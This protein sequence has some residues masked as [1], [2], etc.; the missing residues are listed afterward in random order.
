MT[1][2]CTLVGGPESRLKGQQ[3][4]L[5]IDAPDGAAGADIC[6]QLAQKFGTGTV[7]V[8]GEDLRSVRFG[9]P[10]LVPGAVLI[11]G[12][13]VP[14]RRKQRRRPSGQPPAPLALAV[15]SGPGAGTVVP[16]RRGTYTIGRSNARIVIPDAELSRQHARLVV[17]ETNIIIVDLGSANGTYVDGER[18]RNAAVSTG[19]IIRCGNSTMSM[20][21]TDAPEKALS[22]A[23]ASVQEPILVRGRPES[24]SRTVLVATAGL[25]LI[26]GIGLAVLTGMWMFLA[27]AAA[28]A[29][30]LMVPLISGRRQRR[31]TLAAVNA[32]VDRDRHRRRASG[33]SLATLVLAGDRKQNLPAI[34]YDET[35]AW[36][37]LGQA[38]QPANVMVEPAGTDWKI[39][40]AGTVPVVLDLS[41][42][43]SAFQGTP[44]L[45]DGMIR[46]IIMQ[47]V[48][49]P[50]CRTLRLIIHGQ[51]G[52]LPLSARYLPGVTVTA[53]ADTCRSMMAEGPKTSCRK[54]VLLITGTTE[55]GT[56]NTLADE[57]L[58]RG[59]HVLEF[60]P[61]GARKR[62]VDVEL[63]E[64][65][66][67]LRRPAGDLVF[68]PDLA[69]EEVFNK[70]CRHLATSPRRQD[71]E[72]RSIPSTCLLDDVL[73]Q[74]AAQTAARWALSMKG[75][76]LA[77]PLGLG[78]SGARVLDLQEDGPHLLVAGTTGSGKSE[79]LRSL[80]LALALSHPPDRV[81][82]LFVDFKGGSGLG[83]L[84]GLV[85]CVGLL[86]DLS[87]Y[88]LERTLTSLRAEIRFR[89]EVLA[90]A[91]VPD[92]TA[93][94]SMP[95]C[96]GLVIPHLVIIIDEFRMLVDDA[97]EVLR[98]LMRI[99]SVGR[100]LGIHLVMATQRPQG[101]LT[102][103]I[104]ANVTSSIALR[105]QSDMESVDIIGSKEAAAISIDAPGRAFLARG[106]ERAQEFQ[107]ATTGLAP[108]GSSLHPAVNV[109]LAT[110][111]LASCVPAGVD[112]ESRTPADATASLVTLVGDLWAAMKGE[113]PRAPVAPPL[114]QDLQ[115]P[116]RDGP[117]TDAPA[118]QDGTFS[119][120][121]GLMDLPDS[122]KVQ[123]L[124]WKPVQDSHL[125]L[126]GAPASGAA[127]ALDL[128]VR[129][130]LVHRTEA[131]CYF[132]DGA[133]TLQYL[134]SHRR[135]G[136]HAGL[137][138]LRRG[139]RVLERLDRELTRRLSQPDDHTVPLLV[140]ISGWGSW[141]SAFRSGP[142]AWA[143]DLVQNLVRDGARAR[144]TVM[145]SGD[146]EL[147]SSRFCGALPNR[148]YFPAG[149][150]HDSRVAWP[151][152]PSTAAV[153]GRAVA[154]G[155]LSDGNAAV[156]QLYHIASNSS[157]C[158]D[159]V[160]GRTD[161]PAPRPFRVE[162][163]PARVAAAEIR[164]MAA[165]PPAS[166]KP[167][168]IP[169]G[170]PP[171][172]MLIG[173][174]GDELSPVSFR[175]PPGGV[176]A[177]LGGPGSGKTNVLRALQELNPAHR[178]LCPGAGIKD[179][180]WNGLLSQALAGQLPKETVVLADD[181][182]LMSPAA[183]H[184]LSELQAMGQPLVLTAGYSP[185]LLQRVPLVMSSRAAGTG[186]L[187][188][189]RSILDG[190]LFGVRFEVEPGPTPGRGVL[191]SG[192]RSCLIQV[193]WAPGT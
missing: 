156:C 127:E 47:L 166:G 57:A 26:I 129:H 72:E 5:S 112:M 126:I 89:E 134:A 7:T 90:S 116:R 59:W 48:A 70:F 40:S 30:A 65:G 1:L 49:Y 141:V 164:S 8:D 113:S 118:A 94:R 185:L 76:G 104:R 74:S 42:S 181:A 176:V 178:W 151:R 10:P 21:F 152:M 161:S 192:G 16:L 56:S 122:Q 193:G 165:S 149:S 6:Y 31:E 81:T 73:P 14:V 121:L 83:P 108:K 66:S 153:K 95:G 107:A 139:V 84:K 140:V 19:S 91:G 187:L 77:A 184:A 35:A 18:I 114:P 162:A 101:A 46:A 135:V 136:A 97:P 23:G 167:S 120:T 13:G 69:P 55:E 150:N 180:F 100:S 188:S 115:E 61:A 2:H 123:P 11:D 88:E 137:H 54:G 34:P 64:R 38:V 25:P 133:G 173:V 33:P 102:A 44:N 168:N 20:V 17:T 15:H 27:F 144:L 179:D 60:L 9:L 138:E 132:L 190:D 71:N 148:L 67:T 177:V 109:Q 128:A 119:I 82:F 85:H 51:A 52:R 131:H 191:I 12:G 125:A 63:L 155:P 186:V 147:V 130:A 28:S 163:L 79:L 174:G 105:V 41:R 93:Y 169:P 189:P 106:T 183:M 143:E 157:W 170:P 103:D 92:L 22:D 158:S 53:S 172:S 75:A 32:A 36:L 160:G 43:R 159:P 154:F 171:Q 39:P 111:Y 175:F 37:R 110:D 142:L 68:V 4:E 96:G 146:R 182:D 145:I 124:E 98:E 80:T 29:L 99:A 117:S 87:H 50:R 78:P 3:L 24:G 86:T 58:E 45:M 62:G